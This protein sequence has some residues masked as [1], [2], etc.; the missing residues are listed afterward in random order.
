MIQIYD[1]STIL[2]KV[3]TIS[4]KSCQQQKLKQVS[5]QFFDLNPTYKIMLTQHFKSRAFLRLDC[6]L[7]LVAMN[8]VRLWSYAEC[9]IVQV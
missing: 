9:Q 2:N 8:S 6:F 4:Q 7:T 1:Y 5:G 3:W